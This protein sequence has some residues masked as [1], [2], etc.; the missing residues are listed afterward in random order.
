MEARTREILQNVLEMKDIG[1]SFYKDKLYADAEAAYSGALHCLDEDKT[2]HPEIR[3]LTLTL[4]SNRAQSSICQGYYEEALISCDEALT[5]D[6][7]HPKV[8]YRRGVAH[9]KLGHRE[10][11]EGCAEMLRTIGCQKEAEELLSLA[12]ATMDDLEYFLYRMFLYR[13]S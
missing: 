7:K 8:L 4:L 13:M 10:E 12:P 3:A 11:V 5:M 2:G 9:A 1:N 6:P